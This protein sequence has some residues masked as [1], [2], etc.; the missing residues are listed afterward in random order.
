MFVLVAIIPQRFSKS[1]FLEEYLY[2]A[3]AP[4]QQLTEAQTRTPL[5]G[6]TGPACNLNF[7]FT[8]AGSSDHIGKLQ[9][10]KCHFCFYQDRNIPT[11]MSL[12]QVSCQSEW[13][14][15]CWESDPNCGSSV[16]KRETRR[17]PGGTL[18]SLLESGNIASRFQ[19]FKFLTPWPT[20]LRCQKQTH[21]V[22]ARY[23]LTRNL[24]YCQL[25]FEAR[26]VKIQPNATIKV[27]NVH[28]VSCH[29]NYYPSAPTGNF[30]LHILPS[31]VSKRYVN[32][33]F[34]ETGMSCNFEDG[35]CGWYQDTSDGFDWSVLS[36]MDHT[37]GTGNKFSPKTFYL[38]LFLPYYLHLL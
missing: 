22:N 12:L 6:P 20:S 17:N 7:D 4:G 38:V 36:G 29:A 31:N 30:S 13:L 35:L 8:L 34:F 19:I 33:S 37:V 10:N 26:A 25:A 1:H 32:A 27:R 24:F 15:A 21:E 23:D 9:F 3:E 5:L 18:T 2:V 14:T 28:F 16:E 11:I